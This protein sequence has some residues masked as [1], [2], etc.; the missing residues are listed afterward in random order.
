MRY[1]VNDYVKYGPNGVCL[2]DGT[3]RQK[4]DRGGAERLYYILKPVAHPGSTIF[5][6]VDNPALEDKMRYVL[7]QAEIDK[8]IV[9]SRSIAFPWIDDR[10]ARKDAFRAA[11]AKSDQRELLA[12]VRCIYLRKQELTAKGKKLSA[13]DE[14]VLKQAEALIEDEFA[15]SLHLPNG[16]VSRYIEEKLGA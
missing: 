1:A 9:E 8:L 3:T 12:L 6:P 13:T 10:N 16:E 11:I 5:V 15:F 7:T 2:V 14:G 4:S